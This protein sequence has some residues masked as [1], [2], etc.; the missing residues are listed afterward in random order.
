MRSNVGASG[1][2]L[3][4]EVPILPNEACTRRGGPIFNSTLKYIF[5]EKNRLNHL[6][7]C[8]L[9]HFFFLGSLGLETLT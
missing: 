5:M 1:A 3:D 9:R 4:V 6:L 7:S 2:G 8:V